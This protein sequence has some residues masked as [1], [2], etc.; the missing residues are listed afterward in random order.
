MAVQMPFAGLVFVHRL[1]RIST[2]S[3]RHLCNRDILVK[4][5]KC[6]REIRA[7]STASVKCNESEGDKSGSSPLGIELT[8]RQTP[9]SR[10]RRP[11]SPLERISGLLTQDALSPEVMQ[12]MEQ[13]QQG[14]AE[15][16]DVQVSV[17]HCTPEESGPKAD[18]SESHR[19]SDTA[20]EPNTSGAQQNGAFH[21]EK[22]WPTLPGE[23]LL[24]FGEMLVAE[25]RKKRRV[26]FRK[27]FQLQ[28]GTRLQSSWGVILHDDIV[29]QPAG[30]FLKTG[31]GVP[32]LIRRASLDDYVLLMKRGP[33][34]TYPKVQ[35]FFL[36]YSVKEY[37]SV[38]LLTDIVYFLSLFPGCSHYA[39][40]DGC[41]RGGLRV[42][43][44]L[45]VRGHVSVPVQSRSPPIT[46]S[47][48]HF[49]ALGLKWK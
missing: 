40:D 8:S 33:A 3:Q 12:L 36:C 38:V 46:L 6:R 17:T 1:V 29:G 31:R 10:R 15:E 43:V 11:L 45:G 41:H 35:D 7:F 19:A 20:E 18:D 13:N 47:L 34:I 28:S 4:L 2:S 25:Y 32:I 21:E 16:P 27:M 37:G 39:D 44:R 23:S 14:P 48:S 49:L 9:L 26:E 24:A 42:G 30:R 5:H 22:S